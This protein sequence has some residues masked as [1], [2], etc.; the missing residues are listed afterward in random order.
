MFQSTWRLETEIR[1]SAGSTEAKVVAPSGRPLCNP[2][3]K[4]MYID[5]INATLREVYQCNHICLDCAVN[6]IE[7]RLDLEYVLIV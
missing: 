4:S 3:F 6:C 7:L 1:L 5:V 2:R